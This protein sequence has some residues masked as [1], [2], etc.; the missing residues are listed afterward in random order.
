MYVCAEERST[1]IAISILFAQFLLSISP[2]VTHA[3]MQHHSGSC[4]IKITALCGHLP[5]ITVATLLFRDFSATENGQ[6]KRLGAHRIKNNIGLTPRVMDCFRNELHKWE[7]SSSLSS[8]SRW[9]RSRFRK[10]FSSDFNYFARN[11]RILQA[12]LSDVI[13]RWKM[14]SNNFISLKYRTNS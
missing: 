4:A 13:S 6:F 8:L 12:I 1:N 2:G 3:R 10:Y 14:R 11:I 7:P 9:P 5:E